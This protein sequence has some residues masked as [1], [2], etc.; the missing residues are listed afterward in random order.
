M[1]PQTSQPSA[2]RRRWPAWAGGVV[3]IVAAGLLGLWSGEGGLPFLSP[4]ANSSSTEEIPRYAEAQL[5]TDDSGVFAIYYQFALPLKDPSSLDSI[6]DSYD[7]AGYRGSEEIANDLVHNRIPP[8]LVPRCLMLQAKLCLFEGEFVRA[9]A[10]L[11]QAR[12]QL[13]NDRGQQASELDQVIR[14]QGIAALRRAEVENCVECG[15]YSSCIFPIQPRAVH[16]KRDGST[17]AIKYFMEYLQHHPDS[18]EERWLLNL[19]HMTLGQYP[20]MIP[21]PFRIPLEPF[22]S[23]FDIGS[24]TDIADEV[25]VNRLSMAGGAIMEDFNNDGLLDLTLSTL[26]VAGTMA[27]YRNKGDGTFE[28]RT[29]GSGLDKQLGGLYCVQTDYNNDGLA[30]I[31]VCRGGW[32]MQPQRPSLLRNNGDGTFIDVT[33]QA[34][35]GTPVASQTAAWGD[36]DN[37]GLLDLFLGAETGRSLLYRNRGDGTFEELASAAGIANNNYW[38]KGANWGDFDGDGYPDLFLSNFQAPPQ[39]YHNSGDGTFTEVAAALGITQPANCGFSCWFWDYDND[40]WLDLFVSGYERRLAPIIRSHLGMPHDGIISRL[41]RNR[42]GKRFQDVTDAVGLNVA[43]SPMGSNFADFDNDGYLD[44]YLGTGSPNYRM[45][46]PNRM[47]KNIEGKRFAD[48][49]LSSGTGHLQKGHGVACGDWDSDGNIDLFE[50]LGGAAP[51][52]RFRSVL[53][54]NPGHNNHWIT[55]KLQGKKTNRPGLGTR[56][57]IT[58]PTPSPQTIHRHI[59]TGSSFGAN[60]FEQTIGVG[61]AT[62]IETLEIY[63]PAS[64][65]TQIF[66]KLPVDQSIEIT[67]FATAYRKLPWNRVPLPA[68]LATRNH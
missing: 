6:R 4:S 12:D 2:L 38:C 68:G 3:L 39:L 66:H 11:H 13:T 60:P 37:D 44:F 40:G 7:R 62:E 59:S 1:N 28:D 32:M 22:A 29:K 45:I 58:L 33:V 16:T 35:L 48:I 49:T 43:T 47:F 61:Q 56:I 26:D 55:L 24:F 53:F 25:G 20:D 54:Q 57:K 17:E 15:C 63:W 67:E 65:T 41:Y 18:I 9:S 46:V 23:K 42:E 8:A 31:F 10:L 51:G 5:T 30:D 50:E 36:Y 14:L 52:D 21:A 64:R 34:G 19:A 27:L